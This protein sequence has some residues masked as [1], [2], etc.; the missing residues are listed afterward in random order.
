MAF[1]ASPHRLS[2]FL[3]HRLCVDIRRLLRPVGVALTMSLK[4]TTAQFIADRFL[5]VKL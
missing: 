5:Q 4:V 2:A 1:T 3:S